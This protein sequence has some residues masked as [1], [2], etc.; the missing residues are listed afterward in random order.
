M[1]SEFYHQEPYA[2]EF[3][4]EVVES[5]K[6]WIVLNRTLFY[7]GGGGQEHDK[8]TI[9]NIKVKEV[10]KDNGKIIHKVPEHNFC[11]GQKVQ[12]KIFWKRRYDLMKGHTGEHMLFSALKRINPE[13]ELIK[14]SIAE[15]KK[16]LVVQG[17]VNWETADEAQ[18]MILNWISQDLKIHEEIV[19]KDDPGL[20]E[21][22]IKKERISDDRVRIVKIGDIDA[23]AC[24]GIHVNSTS[25]VEFLIISKIN[26]AKPEGD[27]EIEFLIGDEAKKEA[28]RQSAQFMKIVSEL[29]AQKGNAAITV[30]NLKSSKERGDR[31]VKKY[32]EQ[33]LKS[34]KPENVGSTLV[35]KGAFPELDKKAAADYINSILTD[36]SVC[37]LGAEGDLYSL[38]IACTSNLD[39]DC[40]K[41]LNEILAADNG[42]GGG[43]KNYATGGACGE[44]ENAVQRA[45][46]LIQ[47]TLCQSK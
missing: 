2:T 14:I 29:G 43:K 27:W 32:T 13:L 30:E 17:N 35:Y 47:M 34:L 36:D 33:A 23:S 37:I 28:A 15:D 4:A 21:I 46:D 42:K 20:D 26:S 3:S 45:F 5:G 25:E 8:G 7:P 9:E 40:S 11:I 38:T 41:I 39:I 18:N 12:G 1:I 16:Y 24:S 31:I 44:V 10:L 19:S 6:D 22:R